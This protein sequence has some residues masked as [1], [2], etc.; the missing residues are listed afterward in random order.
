MMNIA[1]AAFQNWNTS[2]STDIFTPLSTTRQPTPKEIKHLCRQVYKQAMSYGSRRG[3]GLHGHLAMVVTPAEYIRLTTTTDAN[4]AIVHAPP[5]DVPQAPAVG[6]PQ[7]A[8]NLGA[9]G[10]AIRTAAYKQEAEDFY[11]YSQVKNIILL[12]LTKA[13]P[14]IYI[15]PLS[16]GDLGTSA[17]T[18]VQILEY[19]KT[20]Y[21]AITREDLDEN[22]RD[23]NKQWDPNTHPIAHLW[24]QVKTAQEFPPATDPISDRTA[25]RSAITNIRNTNK[26][27]DDLKRFEARPAAEQTLPNFIIAMQAA[28]NL[29][30]RQRNATTAQASGYHANA[31]ANTNNNGATTATSNP[32]CD[33][34]CWSHGL[35]YNP[36][37]TSAT[38]N[39]PEPGHQVTA[40][41]HN[42]MGGCRQIGASRGETSVYRPPA[43]R[44]RNRNR[45]NNNA[46]NAAAGAAGE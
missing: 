46:A 13:V 29:W 34:Y 19:L 21:G 26:F 39:S 27:E 7:I 33:Y 43:N 12:G 4:G 5:F 1:N 30:E 36:N 3:G 23:L 20:N 15:N 44:N 35:G 25:L 9:P 40:T 37:H 6:G 31:A 11:T 24:T 17:A 2:V 18:P 32:R 10:I 8:P 28:Y 41:V 14:E 22:E 42:K 38:C 16:V 45:P